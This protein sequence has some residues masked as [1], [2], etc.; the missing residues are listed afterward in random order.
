MNEEKITRREFMRVASASAL[1]FSMSLSGITEATKKAD[2]P[3]ILYI[4]ADDHA[5][6]AMS[7]YGSR[8]AN[9]APTP[10]I[11]RLAGEGMRLENCFCTN[12]ICTPSRATIMTGK[13]SHKNGVYTLRDA[14]DPA[15]PN[16]AKY[17][18]QSG[19]QT[20]II[21]KWHLH[22][23]PSGFDY[24]N[25]L[26]GQGRYFDPRFIEI[27]TWK[28]EHH[29]K[30]GYIG[31]V[32]KGYS[33]DIIT[34]MAMEW[35]E[36]S[37]RQRPFFLMCHFKAPHEPW[38]Y[39]KRYSNYLADVEIPEPD[40]LWEDKSHRSEGSR[41]YGYTI[42]TLTRRMLR[43]NYHSEGPIDIKGLDKKQQRKK[44]YQVFLKRYLRTIKGVDD[45]IGRLL[46]FLGRNKLAQNTV[47]IYTSD[48]GY[49]L[50]E[51][52]YID[53]RWIFEES[54]RMPFLVRYPAEIA[55]GSTTDDIVI[56]TDFAPTF[57][58]YAGQPTPADMQGRSMRPILGGVTPSNW[59]SSMYYRYWM[60]TNRP[61][62]YGLRTKR[63]K[64]IFFYGLPLGMSGAS[65]ERTKP[66]W[67]FYDLKKD[68]HELHN[69]YREPEYAEIIKKLKRELLKKKKQLDDTDD[70]YPQLLQL[71]K[72][73][74]GI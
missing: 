22:A 51:H 72:R 71:R 35:M 36:K 4:M 62:H 12:S 64:L 33:T 2:R 21:G 19:Y 24:Y 56:N 30:R 13:Y 65:S 39:A 54:L 44:T 47:V 14:L 55:P 27:G 11:D 58:D 17:L 23:E 46:K 18:R 37:D 9:V 67:E 31:Q 40:S 42:D 69:V 48:Q 34:D 15:Q 26:D 68:P 32:H 28:E 70:K 1:F 53:K 5:A 38:E 49:F 6:N 45:N 8:L 16:V 74:G 20:A 10:N 66:G 61:A 25:V 43:K 50:G 29:K 52:N 60:H 3:N 41:E 7:C 63:Y 73:T 59:R 57:L